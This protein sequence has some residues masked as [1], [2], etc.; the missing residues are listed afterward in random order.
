M[1]ASPGP[2]CFCGSG[3]AGISEAAKFSP[4]QKGS[5]EDDGNLTNM[6]RNLGASANNEVTLYWPAVSSLLFL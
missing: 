3:L 2:F 6:K 1:E 5:S 4:M